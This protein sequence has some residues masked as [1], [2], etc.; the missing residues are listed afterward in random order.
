M[1]NLYS[2]TMTSARFSFLLGLF[3]LAMIAA[4][5]LLNRPAIGL[6]DQPSNQTGVLNMT[7]DGAN[8]CCCCP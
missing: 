7:H 2:P 8:G 4:V 5:V 3:L 6:S 1:R